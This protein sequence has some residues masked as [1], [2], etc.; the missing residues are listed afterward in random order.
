MR[1]QENKLPPKPPNDSK[2][3]PGGLEGKVIK[4]QTAEISETV[5]ERITKQINKI[6][7]EFKAEIKAS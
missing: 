7:G 3:N 1:K 2:G 6:I 4:S 5:T